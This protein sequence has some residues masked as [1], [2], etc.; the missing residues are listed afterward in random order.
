[1]SDR[2]IKKVFTLPSQ[3]FKAKLSIACYAFFRISTA[4]FTVRIP[5]HGFVSGAAAPDEPANTV[6]WQ[7]V[8]SDFLFYLGAVQMA[9][10]SQ[11]QRYCA[12]HLAQ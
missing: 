12:D 8:H 11:D 3:P 4:S 6:V 5:E 7:T 2:L 10:S 1:M 9:G